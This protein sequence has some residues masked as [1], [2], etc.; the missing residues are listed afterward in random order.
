[1]MFYGNGTRAY[2]ENAVD[3][4]ELLHAEQEDCQ[5]G[6][7]PN[8]PGEYIKEAVL[9]RGGWAAY[10]RGNTLS[11]GGVGGVDEVVS[12]RDGGC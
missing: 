2:V 7:R 10:V 12:F 11:V 8:I 3:A 1:M 9:V 6:T 5:S 4:T